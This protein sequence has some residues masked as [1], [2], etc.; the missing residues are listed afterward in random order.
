MLFSHIDQ[1]TDESMPTMETSFLDFHN[2]LSNLKTIILNAAVFREDYRFST[3][4]IFH[5]LQ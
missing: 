4:P 2:N 5:M 3:S 1:N